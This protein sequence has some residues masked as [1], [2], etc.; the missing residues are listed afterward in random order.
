M[1]G[2]SSYSK[3][4]LLNHISELEKKIDA[5]VSVQEHL[6][7]LN[8]KLEYSDQQLRA[9][10]QQLT[11]SEQKIK[12]NEQVFRALLDGIEDVIYVADPDTFELVHGNTAAR[13]NWGED[14][15]GK[16]C[17]KALQNRDE[18]CPFCTNNIIFNP[19]QKGAHVWEFQ[20][21]I[22]QHWYRCSD[23][24]IQWPDGRKLR[25]ELASDITSIKDNE[26]ALKRLNESL[27]AKT[28]ELQQILYITTHDLRSPLVNIQGFS[29]E[30]LASTNELSCILSQESVPETLKAQCSEILEEE[31][32]ESIHYITTSISKMD[33]LLKGLLQ[34]SRLGRQDPRAE[35]LSM[36]ILLQ[37][38]ID[39]FKYEI[40][41]NMIE[42]IVRDL[43]RCYADKDQVNQL[44]ANLIGNAIKFMSPD[45]KGYITISGEES[46]E[47]AIYRVSDNGIGIEDIHQ[48]K[49]FEMFYKLNPEKPGSGLGMNIVKQII[50]KN[51][52]KI[53][54]DSH[55]DQGTEITIKLPIKP[56]KKTAL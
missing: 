9:T 31:L 22:N 5:Q 42:C 54:V 28:E 20:N 23:R 40:H 48:K 3:S 6:E 17:Y 49:I 25:F 26:K 51:H 43:P 7:S 2:I 8:H 53:S 38:V 33:K 36:N 55:I 56:V 34:I 30:L 46:K 44:F 39:S 4:E 35:L 21:E 45:R 47:Y 19:D 12:E 41:K 15:I 24:V 52:G 18:P 50:E 11:A 13:Q 37:Q 16:K 27:E 32:P 1:S 29:K 14:I 10:N